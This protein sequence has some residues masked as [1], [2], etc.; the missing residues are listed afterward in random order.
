MRSKANLPIWDVM[1]TNLCIPKV[2]LCEI[3]GSDLT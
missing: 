3:K 1:S 2:V